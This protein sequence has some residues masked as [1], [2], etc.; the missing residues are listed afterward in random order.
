MVI[1][2]DAGKGLFL[3]TDDRNAIIWQER[4]LDLDFATNNAVRMTLTYD[5]KLGLSQDQFA[6]RPR[7]IWRNIRDFR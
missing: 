4:G 5:G 6:N 3:V 2:Y 1:A 7:R